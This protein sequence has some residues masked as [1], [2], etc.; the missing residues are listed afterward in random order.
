MAHETDELPTVV[1]RMK[2]G[3]MLVAGA[4]VKEVADALRMS[5]VTVRRYQLIVQAGG[6]DALKLIGVGGRA[7]A[8]D[9]EALDWIAQALQGSA[10]VHGFDSDAWTN[11][12]LREVI[13]ARFGVRYSRVYIWQIAT[14]L[15]LGHCLAKS[16][17]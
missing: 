8:L 7:S 9:R 14:N 12:R 1:R 16:T 5:P 6:L 10:R 15:G 2:A 3:R 4:T 17:R 11:S 13:E